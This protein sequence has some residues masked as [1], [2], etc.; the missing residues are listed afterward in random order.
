MSTEKMLR[1][2]LD[3]QAATDAVTRLFIAVDRKDWPVVEAIFTD[4]VA[5]AMAGNRSPVE[6]TFSG[7]QIA[8]MWKQGLGHVSALHHQMGN[9]L[10]EVEGDGAHVF[11][12]G[13]ATHYEAEGEKQL[14]TFTGEYDFELVRQGDDWRISGFH[15][16]S[17]YVV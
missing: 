13:I 4:A 10:A 2:L 12:Y 16:N 9:V 14:T 15:F 17:K 5:F 8:A 7:A 3:R 6:G 1:A 11:C